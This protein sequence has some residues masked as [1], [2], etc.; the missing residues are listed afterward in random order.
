MLPGAGR[1]TRRVEHSGCKTEGDSLPPRRVD[2]GG[3][4]FVPSVLCGKALMSKIR[5][6][7]GMSSGAPF[8]ISLQYQRCLSERMDCYQI[9]REGPLV[10]EQSCAWRRPEIELEAA[11]GVRRA[12][13]ASAAEKSSTVWRE[14]NSG[15]F[16]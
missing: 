6:S 13:P 1:E 10:V 16:M 11:S 9:L 14:L 12:V 8:L 7:R 2:S 15:E 4:V 3:P 5:E